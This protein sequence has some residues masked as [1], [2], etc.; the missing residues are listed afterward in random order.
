M[1]IPTKKSLEILYEMSQ[2]TGLSNELEPTRWPTL[3][4]HLSLHL[5]FPYVGI[6]NTENSQTN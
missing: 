4:K 3:T 5:N 2:I 6:Y 1:L